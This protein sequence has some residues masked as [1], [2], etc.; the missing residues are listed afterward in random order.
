MTRRWRGA[1]GFDSQQFQI[2]WSASVP[3][4]TPAVK[5]VPANEPKALASP[6]EPLVLRLK[7][8]FRE[9]VPEPLEQ[10]IDAGILQPEDTS[11]EGIRSI[12][13]EHARELLAV[14]H[15]L[16]A[17]M[18]ARRRGVAPATGKPPRTEAARARL[19]ERFAKE[20]GQL[21]YRRDLLLAS[22][23]DAFGDQAAEAFRKVV[24]ARHAGIKVEAEGTQVPP[25]T[26]VIRKPESPARLI[27]V[28]SS[29]H[30][31][32]R[33]RHC[34]PVPSPLQKAVQ[35][36]HF[37]HEDDGKPVRPGPGEIRAITEQHAVKLIELLDELKSAPQ[38]IKL[39]LRTHFEAALSLYAEDFGEE[40]AG[41][42]LAYVDREASMAPSSRQL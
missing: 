34:V 39:T 4:P 23:A 21:E 13:E 28:P 14:L 1:R 32:R 24:E 9:S 5:A 40:A 19:K 17:L 6:P 22:Y 41:R 29:T 15:D 7:W 30:V 18:D 25:P 27:P 37:G 42:L 38:D 20:P 8:D 26:K 35:A 36:G 12:H 33:T 3:T 11:P 31:T 10:A 16:S 2:D